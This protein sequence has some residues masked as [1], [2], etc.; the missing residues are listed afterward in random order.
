MTYFVTER[1]TKI[2]ER[3]IKNDDLISAGL[4]PI[5]SRPK[6]LESQ[7]T[8][9]QYS[10]STEPAGYLLKPVT[11]DRL[12]AHFTREYVPENYKHPCIKTD[13]RTGEN[14]NNRKADWP[15]FAE[16][17]A[18]T[19]LTGTTQDE[20]TLLNYTAIWLLREIR[21]L[22]D[23]T[24]Q[25]QKHDQLGFNDGYSH[26]SLRDMG[27]TPEM[28]IS[29]WIGS[30][31]QPPVGKKKPK[32]LPRVSSKEIKEAWKN[33]TA[34]VVEDHWPAGEVKFS[35]TTVAGKNVTHGRKIRKV[36]ITENHL[37]SVGDLKFNTMNQLVEFSSGVDRNGKKE[38]LKF[39]ER[40]R[41]SK[42]NSTFK[43]AMKAKTKDMTEARARYLTTPEGSNLP[44]KG[45]FL[46]GKVEPQYS[47][48]AQPRSDDASW[49]SQLDPDGENLYYRKPQSSHDPFVTERAAI[50][51]RDS[52]LSELERYQRIMTEIPYEAFLDAAL[53]MRLDECGD[54]PRNNKQ[55]S[56]RGRDR[57]RIAVS[58]FMNSEYSVEPLHFE[59]AA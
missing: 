40:T 25:Q 24:G 10:R 30:D 8:P 15:V 47:T 50:E 35:S 20:T 51:A 42:G 55:A 58:N 56:A 19:L 1:A 49:R 54:G 5:P 39:I 36:A 26:D 34:A 57:I 37:L 2:E 7:P 41:E 52:A 43:A 32:C 27:P 6:N 13:E 11:D 16:A 44:W 3:G 21:R 48:T 12:D 28:I 23:L 45:D 59:V 29:K 22:H 14:D 33:R 4:P 46:G 17:M 18:G 9:M 38:W 53:G 31:P